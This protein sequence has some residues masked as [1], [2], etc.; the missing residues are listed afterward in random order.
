MDAGLDFAFDT[1]L[2]TAARTLKFISSG[3]ESLPFL[4]D[5]APAMPPG[6]TTWKGG[7]PVFILVTLTNN[8]EQV[9]HFPFTKAGADYQFDLD[10]KGWGAIYRTTDQ[11]WESE[12]ERWASSA[13]TTGDE[14]TLKA[15]ETYRKRIELS[16]LYRLDTPG[17][18]SF[19][20]QMNLP[21]QLGKGLVRS[22]TITITVSE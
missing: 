19:Q 9:L 18:D 12:K 1:N 21:V 14:I 5:I 11:F 22:N 13:A 4:L 20:M 10:G 2:E 8:T 17:E 15:H 6:T 16:S 7:A 3:H